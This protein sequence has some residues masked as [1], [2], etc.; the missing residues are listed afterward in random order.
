MITKIKSNIPHQTNKRIIQTL[1]DL[2]KWSFAKDNPHTQQINKPDS[3]LKCISHSDS[4]PHTPDEVL[5]IYG[6]VIFDMV[7][8]NSILKF[9]TLK[10]FYWNWYH[11]NSTATQFH[12]DEDKDTTYTILYNLHDNDGGTEFKINNEIKFEKSIESEALIYPSKLEHRGVAPKKDL[13][14]FNLNIVV[15]V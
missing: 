13:H 6:T 12:V 3:G 1:F 4:Q 10:R 14:R 2:K 15:E 9:K 11:Q 7:Q 5:N 8:D